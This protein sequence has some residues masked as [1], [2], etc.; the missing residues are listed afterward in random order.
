MREITYHEQHSAA[1]CTGC[2]SKDIGTDNLG[3]NLDPANLLMYGKANP[4]DALDILGSF[5]KGVHAKDGEYPTEPGSLG[6]EKPLGQGRVNFQVLVPK[7]KSF[8]YSGALSIERE[9]AGSQQISD[10]KMAMELLRPLL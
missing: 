2:L 8:G 7:L 1:G 6:V 5:I 3:V 10:I 4:V 9:I